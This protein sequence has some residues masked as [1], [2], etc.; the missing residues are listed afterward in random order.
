MPDDWV[1]ALAID[2]QGRVWIG[3][4]LNGGL[5]ML[6]VEAAPGPES[7][8]TN[9]IVWSTIIPSAGLGIILIIGLIIVFTRQGALEVIT[10]RDFFI[11]F[12]G[13]FAINILFWGGFYVLGKLMGPA[14]FVLV[15]ILWMPP[16]FSIIAILVVLHRKRW[17]VALGVLSAFVMNAIGI[18]LVA[19]PVTDPYYH[20]PISDIVL[21]I[22]FFL[23][24]AGL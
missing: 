22:P 2:G 24:G 11:G 20:S 5:S 14:G 7:L 13:W 23:K 9:S 16:V 12:L 17:G 19:P 18:I 15:F 4:S 6:D 1:E 10:I 3:S 8:Q 21:M